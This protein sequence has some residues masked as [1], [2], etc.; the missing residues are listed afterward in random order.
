MVQL[1]ASRMTMPPASANGTD[2]ANVKTQRQMAIFLPF[3]SLI[4]GSILPAGLFLYW[5]GSTLF[6]IGQQ[7]LIIGWGG[8]F[9]IF[10]WTPGFA[11]GH[12]PRFPVAAAAAPNEISRQ[13]GTTARSTTER[14]QLDRSAS[15]AATVRQRGRQGRRGRRR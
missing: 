4:Y 2:D 6:S 12:E 14:S 5:I 8:M 11:V 9:P 7:Y 15:A 13:A 10:G 1:V 3:I